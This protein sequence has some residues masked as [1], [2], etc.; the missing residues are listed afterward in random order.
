[1][2]FR[3]RTVR[4][5]AAVAAA[6]LLA[7]AAPAAADWLVTRDGARVET[8][9]AWE[10]K[11]RQVIFTRKHGS[12]SALRL[13]DVDIEASEAAT[14]AAV[15]RAAA[16][17]EAAAEVER[18]PVERKPVLVLTD[19]DIPRAAASEESAAAEG[20]AAAPSRPAAPQSEV[21]VELVSWK[22]NPSRQI[23][24][25]ELVG[26]VRNNGDEVAAKVTV[27]V[28]IPDGEGGA[29]YETNA[30]LRSTGLPP[31]GSTTFRALLPGIFQL[32]EDPVFQVTAAGITL[33]GRTGLPPEGA[34]EGGGEGGES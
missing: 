29:L 25:L 10:V 6:L 9:G 34:E 4:P 11:G 23:D 12:L 28:T 24:G 7:V 20:G 18:D 3:H 27:K 16:G 5:S 33:L 19:K 26:A 17:D 15:A 32:N 21:P 14:A 22:A 13:D 2:M 30:F 1:M 8:E 31:G